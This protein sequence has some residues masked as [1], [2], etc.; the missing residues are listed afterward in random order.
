MKFSFAFLLCLLYMQN[1][2][3]QTG[4]LILPN[5]GL[6]GPARF[7][8][9][10][11]T[12]T[13]TGYAVYLNNYM[14]FDNS[15]KPIYKTTDG[16]TTWSCVG[17]VVYG[18]SAMR[19]IEFLGD[20]NTGIAG[21][22]LG[23][24]YRT[25]DAGATWT[26]ISASIADTAAADSTPTGIRKICGIAHWGNTFYGVGWWG[27][28]TGHVYKSTD[29][30]LTWSTSYL[31]TNLATGLVD[32]V[33]FSQDSGFVTG[34]RNVSDVGTFSASSD[35]SVILRTYDGGLTWTKVFSDTTLGGRIW[36]IQ[37]LDRQTIVGSI[38]P[39]YFTDSVNM[40]RS[41]DG[42]NTWTI[43]HAGRTYMGG[44]PNATQGV[45]FA[46]KN[47]GWLG[48]YYNGLYETTDGGATWSTVSF[49]NTFNR[50]FVIDSAHVF[51]GGASIYK[52]THNYPP[53]DTTSHVSIKSAV[54]PHTLRDVSPN[55]ATGKVK[56]EFSL[57]KAT[58][59][60]LQVVCVDSRKHASIAEGHFEHG[61]YVYYW[62]GAS[63]PPGHYMVWLG[64]DE[65]PIAKRFV[66]KH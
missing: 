44:Y 11:F 57:G 63:M 33:F 10:Y 6:P 14:S 29:K 47:I 53:P 45:G 17:P 23:S 55:P 4:W 19:S 37:M 34:G 66:L 24:V 18:S 39:Y 49:G 27:G 22:L 59:V 62:D 12:D 25:A 50:F 65:V 7:E 3:C 20:K 54:A 46:T 2:Q 31:D 21:S 43:I 42:G 28:R 15:P 32:A 1:A 52:W 30:G 36:K 60:V 58:N 61:Q 26:D 16:G 5:Y 56:I 35:E 51:A 13:N 40:V 8:D 64:T 9:V 38:E 48:G 41:T